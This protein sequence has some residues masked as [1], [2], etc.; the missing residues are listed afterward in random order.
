MKPIEVRFSLSIL[1]YSIIAFCYTPASAA[2]IYV[3][4]GGSGA[5]S[6]NDPADLQI[7][8]NTAAANMED[9]VIYLEMG[10]Y[11]GNFTYTPTT[12][13]N[14]IEIQGGWNSDFS[15]RT[16]APANTIL[17]GSNSGRVLQF[18]DHNTST[19]SS[20]ITVE[21]I[22]VQ[23]GSADMGAGIYAYTLPPGNIVLR[24]NIVANNHAEG[25][26]GGILAACDWTSPTGCNINISNNIIY[27]NSATGYMDGDTRE[28]GEGGGCFLLS[29]GITVIVNNL[30]HDNTAGTSRTFEGM[31]GG[32]SVDIYSGTLNFTNNTVTKNTAYQEYNGT[33]GTGGGVMI[34]TADAPWGS[35]DIHLFNSII[36]GN[37]SESP[38]G[39]NDI[40]QNISTT[41]PAAGSSIEIRYC[42]YTDMNISGGVSPITSNNLHVFPYF[43]TDAATLYFLTD[44]SQCID[45]GSN[46]A[47]SL[48][49]KDLAGWSRPQDGDNNGVAVANM[50]SYEQVVEVPF[51][52][53]TIFPAIFKG[54]D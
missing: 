14:S 23:R 29:T 7:A 34:G 31:G 47:P 45:A 1:F 9:D 21:G 17:D 33:N 15:I 8:L 52:W 39:A 16:I 37:F 30:I 2:D 49:N 5:G 44:K 28:S 6:I 10:T 54:Q 11:S 53:T 50:G 18:N 20:S 48:P 12:D 27:N 40:Y 41:G 38:Q 3:S 13:A 42:N 25:I 19:V 22:T 32:I 24:N 43:S 26:G 35:A 51:P 4:P 36:Y 46:F